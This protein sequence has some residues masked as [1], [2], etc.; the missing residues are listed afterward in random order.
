[1]D[2]GTHRNYNVGIGLAKRARHFEGTN[3]S[4]DLASACTGGAR[5]VVGRLHW[6]S[7]VITKARIG[8][9]WEQPVFVDHNAAQAN[10]HGTHF[11]RGVRDV[12]AGKA[13]IT[14]ADDR[15]A[16]K[17]GWARKNPGIRIIVWTA[18]EKR[19]ELAH[20]LDLE[21]SQRSGHIITGRR[22]RWSLR[23]QRR[24]S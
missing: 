24:G 2:A 17:Q 5:A 10:V 16:I 8:W 18:V 14:A 4:V 15:A 19:S 23:L 20:D 6:G 13:D 9:R 1:M 3:F 12:M 11:E 22:E 7:G 21:A